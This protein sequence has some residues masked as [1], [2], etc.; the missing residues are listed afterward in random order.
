MTHPNVEG[1]PPQVSVSLPLALK[2]SYLSSGSMATLLAV[3]CVSPPVHMLS[4]LAEV[5]TQPLLLAGPEYR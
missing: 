4:V 3:Y 5:L 1:G 2:R